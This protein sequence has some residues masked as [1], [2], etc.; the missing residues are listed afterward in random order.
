MSNVGGPVRAALAISPDGSKIIYRAATGVSIPLF[1]RD[2]ERLEPTP[3]K[4][5]TLTAWPFT[6]PDAKWIGFVERDELKKIPAEGGTAV[7]LCTVPTG[8]FLGAS[9]GVDDDIVFALEDSDKGL[10]RVSAGGGEPQVLTRP[11]KG[12]HEAFHAY[13]AILPGRRSVLFTILY[14]GGDKADAAVLDL[15]TGKYR[16]IISGATSAQYAEPG[17]VVYASNG[18][19]RVASLDASG[20][21]TAASSVPVLDQVRTG[22]LGSAAFAVSQNGTLVY[23]RS[24]GLTVWG[25]RNALM[26]PRGPTPW[27]D[28]RQMGHVLRL[29]SAKGFRNCGPGICDDRR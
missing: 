16:T 22:V 2:L 1:V 17:L 7:P 8:A 15:T 21:Q 4:G 28:C 20:A 23:G 5:A 3:V 12:R 13:P 9:W 29:T 19:L 24:P 14:D 25:A 10:L 26:R 6:S 18:G 11:D 27:Y